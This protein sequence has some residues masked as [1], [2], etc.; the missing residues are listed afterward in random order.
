M[1]EVVKVHI[2]QKPSQANNLT[3]KQK[4]K[5]VKKAGCG[6]ERGLTCSARP[7][8]A[9]DVLHAKSRE[10]LLRLLWPYELVR[11]RHPCGSET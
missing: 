5:Q 3:L 9:H 4:G 7:G 1:Q 2:L 6:A 8:R 11:Q 10:A